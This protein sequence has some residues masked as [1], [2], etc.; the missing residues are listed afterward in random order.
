M[1]NIFKKKEKE[2]ERDITRLTR[3]Y[4][5]PFHI[6][7]IW[8]TFYV[9]PE[10]KAFERECWTDTTLLPCY[11]VVFESHDTK[12]FNKSGCCNKCGKMRFEWFIRALKKDENGR[13]IEKKIG[14]I[15]DL[16]TGKIIEN[17]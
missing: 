15:F 12:T 8:R 11:T 2:P 13:I 3:V 1:F 4:D 9:C 5:N 16:M 17:D 7:D 10:C 14:K 6:D